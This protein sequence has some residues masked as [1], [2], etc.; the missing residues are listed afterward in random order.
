MNNF[1]DLIADFNGNHSASPDE[2][3]EASDV[4]CVNFPNDYVAFLRT[5]NGGEGMIGDTYL[6]FWQAAELHEM[7]ASYQVTDYAPGLLLI[8]SDGGGEA[9]AFD[10]RTEPWPVVKVPFVGMDLASVEIA[11]PSFTLYLKGLIG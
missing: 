6:I 3:R 1:D 9:I 7:N 4:F 5:S 11:A 10:T 2:I 8:G